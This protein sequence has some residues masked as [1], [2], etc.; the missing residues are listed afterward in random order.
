MEFISISYQCCGH[1][2]HCQIVCSCASSYLS[3]TEY[4]ISTYLSIYLSVGRS[5]GRSV[6]LSLYRSFVRFHPDTT[7]VVDWPIKAMYLFINHSFVHARSL[8]ENSPGGKAARSDETGAVLGG[9]NSPFFFLFFF[10]ASK[11]YLFY[12]LFESCLPS[13]NAAG[14]RAT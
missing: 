6:G 2:A 12:V 9:C 10:P 8:D 13:T 4:I 7:H 11:A 14:A 1:S 5:V 3:V